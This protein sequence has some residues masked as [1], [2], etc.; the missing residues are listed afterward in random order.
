MRVRSISRRVIGVWLMV[1]AVATGMWFSAIADSLATR[2]TLSVVALVA[3]LMTAAL[4]ATA[5]WLITQQRPQGPVLGT[6]ALML[7]A[8][9]SLVTAWSGLLPTNLDPAWRGPVALITTSA[10]AAAIAVLRYESRELI[11]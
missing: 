2:D 9:F 1:D 7:L 4:S 5:G 3:R 8:A 10:A 6:V 11:R